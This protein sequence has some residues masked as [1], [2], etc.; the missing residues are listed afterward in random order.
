MIFWLTPVIVT[1]LKVRIDSVNVVWNVGNAAA[2]LAL[3]GGLR[4]D[5]NDLAGKTFRKVTGVRLP[6]SIVKLLL[7]SR[8]D[9]TRW[10]EAADARFDA[11]IDIYSSPPGWQDSAQLQ[12]EF[13]AKQDA[14]TRR[15]KILYTLEG[16]SNVSQ[17]LRPGMTCIVHFVW[18]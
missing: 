9:R 15:A 16:P 18:D 11:D 4:I 17:R 5:M 3:P 13:I 12:T 10:I 2:E 6:E 14:D 8:Q 7:A 1:F